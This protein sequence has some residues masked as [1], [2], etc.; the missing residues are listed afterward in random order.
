M[1]HPVRTRVSLRQ[2][3]QFK[4]HRPDVW[5]LWFGRAF[6]KEGNCRFDFNRPDDCLSWSGRTH[7]RY[8]NWVL[9][10]SRPYAHPPWSG[11]LNPYK[12]IT[13]SGRA[14]VRTMCH[15]VRTRLLNRKDF[16]VKFLENLV[17]QLSVRTAHVH[18]PN[19]AQVYFAWHSFEPLA[20]K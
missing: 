6:I 15:P 16:P 17:A 10:F 19:G 5:Q 20:Y 14:T 11:S 3:S 1:W 7:I 4:Y 13:C 12:E 2:E 8:E 18:R 9:K